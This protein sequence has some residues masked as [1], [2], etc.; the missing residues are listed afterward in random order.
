[1]RK[2]KLRN[3]LNSGNR[4]WMINSSRRRVGAQG[5]GESLSYALPTRYKVA[6]GRSLLGGAA[7]KPT[8]AKR[9][10]F[11]GYLIAASLL[12]LVSC[13]PTIRI[14]TEYNSDG[15]II[16]SVNGSKAR[17]YVSSNVDVLEFRR[18]FDSEYKTKSQFVST[19][20]DNLIE[21]LATLA[22]VSKGDSS[23]T[24]MLFLGQSFSEDRI[25]AVKGKFESANE[26]YFIGIKKVV[27]SNSLTSTGP[28]YFPPTMVSTPG[29]SMPVGGGFVGGG[30]SEAC[31]V[32]LRAEIWSVRH[33]RKV[34]EFTSVGRST[35]FLF[36][37]GTALTD[38][39]DDAIKSLCRYVKENKE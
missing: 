7:S 11:R 39:V 31:V 23:E 4:N 10:T 27:I 28:H 35:V 30:Q 16:T 13:S 14:V 15:F 37:Y 18:S 17:L 9:G 29:G 34:S 32:T 6:S 21:K 8:I 3:M 1:M 20:S 22:V 12:F 33:K 5:I 25:A 24:D 38:A 26:D 19:L 2:E 36:R